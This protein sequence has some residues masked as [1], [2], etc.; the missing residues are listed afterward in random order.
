MIPDLTLESNSYIRLDFK[1]GEL[2]SET[3]VLLPAEFMKKVGFTDLITKNLSVSS[4]VPQTQYGR[5]Y[6]A[7]Q[8]ITQ[9][10]GGY[11]N[12]SDATLLRHEPT[13]NTIMESKT[14]A[15]QSTVSRFYTA[16]GNDEI[17]KLNSIIKS[18]RAIAYEIEPPKIVLFDLDT[19]LLATYGE[20]EG[21]DFNNHY[22]DN[23]YHPLLMFDSM[24]G[25][26]IKA[27]LREGAK[28]CSNGAA[29]FV[30]PVLDEYMERYPKTDILFR[31]DAGFADPKL[32]ETLENNG[33]LY[34]IKLKYNEARSGRQETLELFDEFY[35]LLKSGNLNEANLYGEFQYQAASWSYPRRVVVRVQKPDSQMFA[36]ATYIVSNI[37]DA[38][39]EDVFEFYCK[40][41][42]MENSIKEGKNGFAFNHTP[43]K[44]MAVNSC[45][46]L[47]QS[48]AYNCFNFFKRLVLPESMSKMTVRTV[49]SH[50]FRI[51]SRI[52]R[53]ARYINFKLCNSFTYKNE[54]IETLENIK[55]LPIVVGA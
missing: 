25:D 51:A 52:V 53:H 12:E 39:P 13:L 34:A 14:L 31:G 15:S 9:S 3:G 17:E 45:R 42:K 20:Q 48:I 40:R 54:F 32:Y 50:L 44:D 21:A 23:G 47:L 36:F 7:R 8:V 16:L 19:T 35:E 28:Y 5:E 38:S 27:E 29:D 22:H 6:V 11:F 30:L 4:A 24:T 1:G 33:A 41:G 10:L 26:L 18:M 55:N 49:R 37:T 46:L 2:S 43:S